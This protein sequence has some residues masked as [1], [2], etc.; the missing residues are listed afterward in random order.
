MHFKDYPYLAFFL[1]LIPV[2]LPDNK[3]IQTD[4]NFNCHA[5]NVSS[6]YDE[7]TF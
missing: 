2:D 3:V 5:S 4:L 6:S 7:M 1:T